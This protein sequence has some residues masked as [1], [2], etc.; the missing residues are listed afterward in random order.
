MLKACFINSKRTGSGA[1]AFL[2]LSFITEDVT[3]GGG[4]KHFGET[5]KSTSAS[6]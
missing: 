6:A 4:L 3:F 5:S 2:F 1:S